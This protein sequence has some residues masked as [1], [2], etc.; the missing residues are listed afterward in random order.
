[1]FSMFYFEI[2][3]L[4][5]S[6]IYILHSVATFSELGLYIWDNR[7]DQ[8]RGERFSLCHVLFQMFPIQDE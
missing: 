5:R 8:P 2:S 7:V 4:L 3:K 6:F 1:M